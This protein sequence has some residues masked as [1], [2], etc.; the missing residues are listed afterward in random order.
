LGLA[1]RRALAQKY[2]QPA[3]DGVPHRPI[4]VSPWHQLLDSAEKAGSDHEGL[5]PWWVTPD[6]AVQCHLFILPL[7]R[8]HARYERLRRQRTL[9]RLALGQA[10]Q[11]DF[12]AT[13][14]QASPERQ[15][16]L[17]ELTLRLKPR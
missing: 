2:G 5:S 13:L 7:S 15:Q 8:D 3:A 16:E 10:N 14:E 11:E 4:K 1:G 12:M 17:A 6:S 9:Y